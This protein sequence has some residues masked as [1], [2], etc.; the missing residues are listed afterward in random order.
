MMER[1]YVDSG[2]FI[3]PILKNLG[4]PTVAKC[5]QWM[6]RIARH[7]VAACTSYLTWDEVTYV[8]GRGPGP[9]DPRRAAAAG[10]LLLQLDGL[11]F[12][13]V[14]ESV[15]RTAQALFASLGLRS[16]DLIH[17]ASALLHAGGRILTVDSDFGRVDHGTG[18]LVTL[19]EASE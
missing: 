13:P 14:D 12:L 4:Q 2:V 9:Y 1:L 7:E 5:E 6:D 19:V 15:V 8:V 17:G 11:D 3:T 10:E 16:R 18:L